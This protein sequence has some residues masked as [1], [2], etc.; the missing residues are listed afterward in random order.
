MLEVCA[1]KAT[2]FCLGKRIEVFECLNINN[3]NYVLKFLSFLIF[4][5]ME[6]EF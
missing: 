4:D 1:S 6:D 5:F 2:I 3:T